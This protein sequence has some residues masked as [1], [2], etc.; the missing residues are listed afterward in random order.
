M[1]A[2]SKFNFFLNRVPGKKGKM[3]VDYYVNKKGA[4][5]ILYAYALF[6]KEFFSPA[7]ANLSRQVRYLKN[8]KIRRLTFALKS[9]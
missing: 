8:V 1:S 3:S 4:F 6:L 7:Q 5:I 2:K 9:R